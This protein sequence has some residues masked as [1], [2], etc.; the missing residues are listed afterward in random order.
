MRYPDGSLVGDLGDGV[1][2]TTS[3]SLTVPDPSST[4][5]NL[6]VYDLLPVVVNKTPTITVPIVEGSDPQIK[7]I[8]LADA[9]GQHLY[10]N[11]DGVVRVCVGSSIQLRFEATQPDK[12][13]VENGVPVIIPDQQALVYLWR[14]NDQP[15]A[16]FDIPR[17]RSELS[18]DRGVCRIVNIQLQHSG[19]YQCEVS[20]DIGSV[21][22]EPITLEVYSPDADPKLFTNLVVN[23]YGELGLDGWNP[24]TS[25]IVSKEFTS[26]PASQLKAVNNTAVFGYTP[27]MLHP[28]P[29][30]I[31]PGVI[32][33]VDYGSDLGKRGSYFG[34][35]PYKF[36]A[37]GG[38]TYTK[39]YQDIDLSDLTDLIRGGVCGISGL[40]AVFG[41]YI[42]TAISN[43]KPTQELTPIDK[44]TNRR[45]HYFG[46]PRLSVENL[47][48]AG[49]P[50]LIDRVYVTVE[51]FED[52]AR[53][54]STMWRGN[55]PPTL[56][57]STITLHDPYTRAI[58]QAPS[59]AYYPGSERFPTDI[60]QLG[61]SSS[62]DVTDRI[63]FAA[64]QLM[65]NYEE[66]FTFGQYVEFNRLILDRLNPKTN[67]VRIT[68]HF[69]CEDYRLIEPS[70]LATLGPEEVWDFHSW[71]RPH[72]R[73]TFSDT[74]TSNTSSILT[75]LDKPGVPPEEKFLVQPDPR[76]MITGLTFGLIPVL[77]NQPEI[78]DLYTEQALATNSRPPAEVPSELRVVPFDPL[79][80]RLHRLHTT[81][82]HDSSFSTASREVTAIKLDVVSLDSSSYQL[83]AS[84]DGLFP[85]DATYLT[86]FHAGGTTADTPELMNWRVVSSRRGDLVGTSD[87]GSLVARTGSTQASQPWSSYAEISDTV[88]D[89][90]V[91]GLDSR[92]YAKASGGPNS[93][94]PFDEE[95]TWSIPNQ[96]QNKVSYI[97]HYVLRERGVDNAT[98]NL[99]LTSNLTTN[100]NTAY[101]GEISSSNLALTYNSYLLEIEHPNQFRTASRVTLSRTTDMVGSGS[102]EP[103]EVEHGINS[104]GYFY[105]KLPDR[106]LFT[107]VDQGGL[108]LAFS[109]QFV[110]Q[111]TTLPRSGNSLITSL[112][113]SA[114]QWWT[115]GELYG[116][117]LRRQAIQSIFIGPED[118]LVV[119]TNGVNGFTEESFIRSQSRALIKD[120]FYDGLVSIANETITPL[121][122]I[123]LINLLSERYEDLYGPQ[124]NQVRISSIWPFGL[125]KIE[126]YR[127]DVNVGGLNS[128]QPASFK[129]GITYDNKEAAYYPSSSEGSR[130]SV[131]LVP[132][133]SFD[134]DN[135]VLVF[136]RQREEQSPNFTIEEPYRNP[137]KAVSLYAVQAAAYGSTDGQ[138]FG[139]TP[140]LGY[141][142]QGNYYQ[143]DIQ[144]VQDNIIH[145]TVPFIGFNP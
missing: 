2:A 65:P 23:P 56:Q 33:G 132:S 10:V 112:I 16:S 45:Q 107:G 21:L 79:Q 67:K 111:A 99:I 123:N 39:A 113:D 135:S 136:A 11:A 129:L 1:Q 50:E 88:R 70:S 141:D 92:F 54:P 42:G 38:S 52:E 9:T 86:D 145:D 43:Y 130:G 64:D 106:I 76:P 101:V 6:T 128:L 138:V 3:S 114:S 119:T 30:Q 17:L 29:Y 144:P 131:I 40:R 28:R 26:V 25:E 139:G 18:I 73:N 36:L 4:N 63:L 87:W 75:I 117:L 127:G 133:A 95:G 84:Q 72:S 103:V 118:G 61:I 137:N 83:Q 93:A 126:V 109:G 46:A 85:F 104:E 78:T 57:T 110:T 91:A 62:A 14:L 102:L 48:S 81:F 49:P 74:T 125:Q 47:L 12:F 134:T 41:C 68:L 35:A 90:A 69:F 34:R 31:D 122:Q 22:S 116:D 55:Q 108:G 143:V 20:N 96:W 100:P 142:Q 27:D 58:Q 120:I 32:R 77:N 140:V 51:E 60:Y 80:R 98:S 5:E 82:L 53:L 19:V 13:N 15:L 124:G 37:R 7:P 115:A 121:Q 94:I 105:F 24:S 44:R 89:R 8:R 71:H 97:L 59:T 66:R